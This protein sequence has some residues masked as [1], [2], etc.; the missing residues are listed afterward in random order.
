[1]S[2]VATL[3]TGTAEHMHLDCNLFLFF[4]FETEN[5]P[6]NLSKPVVLRGAELI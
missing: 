6:L 4:W 5:K 2:C 1:M 3:G